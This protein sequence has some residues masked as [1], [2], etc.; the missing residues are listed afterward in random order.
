MQELPELIELKRLADLPKG[1]GFIST[2]SLTTHEQAQTWAAPWKVKQVYVFHH[3]LGY[4]TAWVV[5]YLI[6]EEQVAA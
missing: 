1:A 3:K 5:K 6:P 2:T 4:M